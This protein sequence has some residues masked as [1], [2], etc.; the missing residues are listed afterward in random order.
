MTHFA[1]PTF[2]AN[3][4]NSRS[5]M[6]GCTSLEVSLGWAGKIDDFL[7]SFFLK[8]LD[9]TGKGSCPEDIGINLI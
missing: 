6:V 1:A 5:D 2:F 3:D 8:I 9:M 7:L 4:C